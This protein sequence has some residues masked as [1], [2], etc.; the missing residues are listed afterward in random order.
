MPVQFAYG[1]RADRWVYVGDLDGE[2]N[3]GLKCGCTCWDCGLPLQAHLG[4]QKAWHFQHAIEDRNCNPQPMTLLHA[5]IRD[6]LA[7][8][9][10]LTIPA[11]REPFTFDEAGIHWS[12]PLDVEAHDLKFTHGA[13]EVRLDGVQPDVLFELEDGQRFAVEVR[14]SH[15]VDEEKLKLI[16]RCCSLAAE[17]DVSDLPA[18][19]ISVAKVTQV[20]SEARRWKWLVNGRIDAMQ[21]IAT[22]NARWAYTN[23]TVRRTKGL[24][25]PKA[26]NPVTA[27]LK[28]VARKLP[29]AKAELERLLTK[30]ISQAAARNWLGQ[31]DKVFRVAVACA[32]LRLDP[33]DLPVFF[34]QF[35]HAGP[36][37][38]A[39]KHH[40]YSWQVVLFMKFGIGKARF[41]SQE[42][43]RWAAIAMPDRMDSAVTTL[44]INRFTWTAAAIHRYFLRLEAQGLLDSDDSRKLEARVFHSKFRTV[45]DLHLFLGAC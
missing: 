33:L 18:S 25:V 27:K 16:R 1:R 30:G 19:G 29:L 26:A 9:R 13:S 41:T 12:H 5:F 14:Y 21:R 31:Q 17:L 44:S 20:L 3:R 42:A 38:P 10:S 37:D 28:E 40:P 35:T 32:A 36:S 43:A 24:E 6:E 8:R 22:N 4:N 34:S 45:R 15:A 7:L 39:I 2:S 11:L 23:W